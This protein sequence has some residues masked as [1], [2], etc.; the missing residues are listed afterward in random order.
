MGTIIQALRLDTLMKTPRENG[1]EKKTLTNTRQEG[2][3]RWRE[4]GG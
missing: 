1:K 4:A 3:D 2:K